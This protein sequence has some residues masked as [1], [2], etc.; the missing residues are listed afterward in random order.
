M[1]DVKWTTLDLALNLFAHWESFNED[2]IDG[3]LLSCKWH[4]NFHNEFLSAVLELRIPLDGRA[5]PM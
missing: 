1:C 5:P 3:E 4:D 2:H